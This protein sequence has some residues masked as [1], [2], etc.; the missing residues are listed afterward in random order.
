[1]E[2]TRRRHLN[3]IARR[4]TS[5]WSE[6]APGA[7]RSGRR[8]LDSGASWFVVGSYGSPVQERKAAGRLCS[9]HNRTGVASIP[10][11]AVRLPWRER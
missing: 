4:F 10:Q 8:Q 2:M 9:G 1:M 3:G 6:K 7:I 5:A 11:L